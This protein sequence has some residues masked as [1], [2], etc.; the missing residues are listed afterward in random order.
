MK[1]IDKFN[2]KLITLRENFW[3][4][5]KKTIEKFSWFRESKTKKKQEYL[6]QI[7]LQTCQVESRKIQ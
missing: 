7:V 1:T 6:L 3:K 5:Q 2:K 4:I